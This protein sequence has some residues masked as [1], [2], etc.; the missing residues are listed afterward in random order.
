MGCEIERKWS[1]SDRV[2]SL[3]FNPLSLVAYRQGYFGNPRKTSIEAYLRFG[4]D[5]VASSLLI[6]KIPGKKGKVKGGRAGLPLEI[7]LRDPIEDKAMGFRCLNK[8]GALGA[9]R[10]DGYYKLNTADKNVGG[11]IRIEGERAV[12][13]V[14]VETIL[15]SMCGEYE[16]EIDVADA[17][18]FL[19]H[20]VLKPKQLR[21]LRNED[22]SFVR[23]GKDVRGTALGWGITAAVMDHYLKDG[24]WQAVMELEFKN[25]LYSFLF[26]APRFLKQAGMRHVT[27]QKEFGNSRIARKGVSD[28]KPLDAL[29][30]DIREALLL[31]LG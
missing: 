15:S 2:L 28:P 14:K 8:A 25:W 19:D 23:D 21:K 20:T 18:A 9:D 1:V 26:M 4:E 30:A 24:Q 13:R 31:H 5:G 12:F 3:V 16:H 27:G 17:S 29:R 22:V 6:D 10:G 11:R 7:A